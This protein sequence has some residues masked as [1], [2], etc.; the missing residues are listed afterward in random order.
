M[1]SRR[2][3]CSPPGADPSAPSKKVYSI[4]TEVVVGVPAALVAF[5]M[6]SVFPV[7]EAPRF[8]FTFL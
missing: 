6:L 2:C 7:T 1:F 5:H 3:A 4:N 8:L